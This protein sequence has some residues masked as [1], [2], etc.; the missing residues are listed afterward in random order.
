MKA[1]YAPPCYAPD[2]LVDN[3]AH[4]ALIDVAHGEGVHARAAD[5]QALH[6]IDAAQSDDGDDWRRRLRASNRR[7]R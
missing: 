1:G 3:R 7:V 2:G 6:L 5:V 4:A